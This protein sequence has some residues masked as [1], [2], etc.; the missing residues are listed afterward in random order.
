ML[1]NCEEI[2]KTWNLNFSLPCNLKK[3]WKTKTFW[4]CFILRRVAEFC[5]FFER[6]CLLT[7]RASKQRNSAFACPQICHFAW[8]STIENWPAFSDSCLVVEKMDDFDEKCHFRPRTLERF[9]STFVNSLI[10]SKVFLKSSWHALSHITN[11]AQYKFLKAPYLL[12][13]PKKKYYCNYVNLGIE[14]KTRKQKKE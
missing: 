1:I 11:T 8:C 13:H 9:L 14:D 12:I 5:R 6:F 7:Q 4:L 10:I 2:G 3:A